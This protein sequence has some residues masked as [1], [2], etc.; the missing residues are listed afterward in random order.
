[1]AHAEC[2]QLIR[3]ARDVEFL[4]DQR[5]KRKMFMAGEDKPF[6][7][8]EKKRQKR[9]YDEMKRRESAF[10]TFDDTEPAIG[11][12]IESSQHEQSDYD[13]TLGVDVATSISSYH[14]KQLNDLDRCSVPSEPNQFPRR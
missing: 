11:S 13:G 12:H 9:K 7:V 8:K 4:Q 6:K 2:D 14:N 5:C 10:K 3:I 1:M